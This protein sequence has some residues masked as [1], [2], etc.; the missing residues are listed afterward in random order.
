MPQVQARLDLPVRKTR[1]CKAG[2]AVTPVKVEEVSE[3]KVK[4]TRSRR[5][6]QPIE[7]PES[8]MRTPRSK[9]KTASKDTP[10]KGST[11]RSGGD[12]VSLEKET[13]VSPSKQART[14][15]K[16]L[17]EN[18]PQVGLSPCS[19]LS[20]LALTSPKVS[21]KKSPRGSSKIRAG[22][23]T[24]SEPGQLAGASVGKT[25]A[26]LLTQIREV[27]GVMRELQKYNHHVTLFTQM[28][29]RL[30]SIYSRDLT[31]GIH[32][33]AGEL[34]GRYSGLTTSCTARAKSLQAALENINMFDRELAEFL[35]WLG[36]METS[37][38]RLES[39][40][41]PRT[42]RLTELQGELRTRDRQFS[43]LTGRGKD[44]LLAA[45]DSD[46]VL[47][48]KVGELG[49]RWS[50]LQNMMMTIQDKLERTGEARDRM[51]D[52]LVWLGEKREEVESIAVGETLALVRRQ[53]EENIAFR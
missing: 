48:S 17:K 15:L 9:R 20:R 34:T 14:P 25:R 42:E 36:E 11:K 10:S 23:S 22:P 28:C 52:I 35:A 51:E 16:Q 32:Q 43:S 13:K 21:A 24:S 50:G 49:R 7:D 47:A 2:K 1:S 30:V 39:Q 3:E 26:V 53:L 4:S 37:L 29:Q 45:G 46:I 31:D 8:L 6:L 38:E 40:Q 27:N 12:T 5:L 19:G 41:E 33:L 18:V 44:Q